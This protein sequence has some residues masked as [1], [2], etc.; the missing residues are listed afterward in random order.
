MP[1]FDVKMFGLEFRLFAYTSY[2]IEDKMK[3]ISISSIS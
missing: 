3:F 1:K 2:G